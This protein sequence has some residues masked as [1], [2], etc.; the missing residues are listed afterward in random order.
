MANSL[1]NIM[2]KI[3]ARGLMALRESCIMPGLV[4]TDYGTDAAQKGA[5][6]DIPVS[7]AIATT[8]VT[9]SNVLPAPGDTTPDLVQVQL[10]KWKKNTPF[11]LTDK[12]L[13]EIDKNAHFMP[14]QVSEAIRGLANQV[15]DDIFAAYTGVGN[16]TNVAGDTIAVA[17]AIDAR[18]LLNQ[19][20]CPAQNRAFVVNYAAE[21]DLLTLA[22]FS[23]FNTAGGSG[24]ST[25]VSGELGSRYGFRWFADDACPL[26][27]AG[28]AM[29]GTPTVS[30]AHSIG[31]RTLSIAHDAVE[32]VKA[33]DSFKIAGDDTYYAV[34]SDAVTAVGVSTVTISPALKVAPSG[35]EAI[36]WQATGNGRV[37]L[38]FHRDA[39]AFA[40]R[41]LETGSDLSLGSN[42]MSM[43]DDKTGLS[44]RLE[45]QRQYKQ[46]TWEFDI[47]YGVKCVRPEFAC[48]VYTASA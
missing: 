35:S 31:T 29:G 16:V 15:N 47:L 5:T 41:P 24:E 14:M 39:F 11:H 23:Q 17:D 30:G 27:T 43:T 6:I 48:K 32:T 9:P 21:A 12:Q 40:T 44:L 38:A 13:G 36:T 28:T 19:S 4:N 45:V 10:D 8:D 18:K 42:I 2:P 26:H 46:T 3:L 7:T 20:L 33:G 1:N 37:G 22:Q 25:L 34:V